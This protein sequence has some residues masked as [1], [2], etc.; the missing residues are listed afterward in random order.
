MY[1]LVWISTLWISRERRQL[2]NLLQF[3]FRALIKSLLNDGC[4][5]HGNEDLKT[6]PQRQ[7]LQR[8]F[9]EDKHN[10]S[11]I[12]LWH[13]VLK[14]TIYSRRSSIW[15]FYRFAKLECKIQALKMLKCIIRVGAVSIVNDDSPHSIG[16]KKRSCYQWPR[17]RGGFW[18]NS[19][20]YKW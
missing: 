16:V 5:L 12:Q 1:G 17:I 3:Q 7:K 13:Q 6:L 20:W 2:N 8:P 4:T 10:F 11:G 15:Q 18:L 9:S 19:K 14:K